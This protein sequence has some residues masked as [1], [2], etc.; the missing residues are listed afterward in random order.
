VIVLAA[1][2]EDGYTLRYAAN[3]LKSDREIV[4]SST[5]QN[6]RALEYAAGELKSEIRNVI[7]CRSSDTVKE[8]RGMLQNHPGATIFKLSYFTQV[9]LDDRQ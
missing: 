7:C 4:L 9:S 3:D 2:T 8:R 6:G 1:V 5:R